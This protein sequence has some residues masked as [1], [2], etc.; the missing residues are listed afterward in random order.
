MRR[1]LFLACSVVFLDVTFF[2]VLT[3]LLPDYRDAHDLT[4]GG[5]GLLSGSFAAGTLVMALPAGWF[6]AHFG[7]RRAVLTGLVGIGV[8]S[9]IFG[10]TDQ[11]QVLIG[12]R[13]L[14]G[15]S[16]A[17]MWAGAMTWVITS[18]PP[19]RRGA[20]I[21]TVIAAAVVGELTGAPLG[22]IAHQV[23]TEAVFG[24]V[25]ILAL[26]LGLVALTIPV[27]GR[28]EK[29]P[30][31][32]AVGAA[33]GS[34]LGRAVLV[35]FAPSFAFG[36]VIVVAPLRMD[37]LG[38]SALLIAGA[39]AAGSVTEALIGPL[40]GRYSD[41]AGRTGPYSIGLGLLAV[42]VTLIGV[43]DLLPLMVAAIVLMAFASGIAFTPASSLVA[44]VAAGAG[45]NQ[46]YASG[47]SNVAWGGGQ[48]AGAF[49]GGVLSGAAGYFL[50]CMLT[51][52][53]LGVVAAVARGMTESPPVSALGGAPR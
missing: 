26:A 53:F 32:T 42:S 50:P 39:F 13:F 5:V 28:P 43:L 41:R 49:A 33:R 46:G 47:A 31:S 24:S 44:D 52:I 25:A 36:L 9:P 3:P 7:P 37:D 15:A 6:A 12:S 18:G 35:L 22:A 20:L 8:F 1:L 45:L 19:E 29:Q 17:L 40:I 27:T 14:Q 21:G 4:E 23:G 11:I 34:S 38:A 2:A 30:L 16:G 48:M 51:V 10:F